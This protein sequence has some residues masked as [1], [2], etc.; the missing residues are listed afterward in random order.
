MADPKNLKKASQ[1]LIVRCRYCGD[2]LQSKHR[3]DFRSCQCEAIFVDG[4]DD[5]FRCGGEVELMEILHGKRWVPYFYAVLEKDRGKIELEAR[6]VELKNKI[7]ESE[8]P[9]MDLIN[10]AFKLGVDTSKKTAID[11]INQILEQKNGETTTA[12]RR[13]IHGILVELR[14]RFRSMGS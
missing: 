8:I 14:K 7:T 6:K 5:Y 10:R 3:H 11:A 1:A 2:I 13:I 4:G 12:E 9:P